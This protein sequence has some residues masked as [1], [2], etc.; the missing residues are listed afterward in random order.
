MTTAMQALGVMPRY[1]ARAQ[2][3]L[4]DRDRLEDAMEDELQ[5]LAEA[6]RYEDFRRHIEPYVQRKM[7]LVGDFFMLQ[8]SPH[9]RM[10]E[11]LTNVL[12]MFDELIA[13][14]ASKFGYSPEQMHGG[15]SANGVGGN[16]QLDAGEA[17][18]TP[19]GI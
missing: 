6:L 5:S 13:A 8:V 18:T 15:T 2:Q 4:Y 1:Y 12:A 11:E 16:I 3:F 14:E 10:S 7:R 9:A 19:D 17:A